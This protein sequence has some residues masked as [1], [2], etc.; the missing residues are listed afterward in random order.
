MGNLNTHLNVWLSC[1]ILA[2][3]NNPWLVSHT[4][5]PW[6]NSL[7]FSHFHKY[8]LFLTHHEKAFKL[9][10]LEVWNDEHVIKT[11]WVFVYNCMCKLALPQNVRFLSQNV[12]EPI[13]I[14]HNHLS[15]QGK[16][17]ELSLWSVS[18]C[19]TGCGFPTI[20]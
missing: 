20:Y 9:L 14:G 16:F 13:R 17:N 1:I 4:F 3:H 10:I 11:C 8:S 5:W 18:L 15:E 2:M 19:K 6:A 7:N 12:K